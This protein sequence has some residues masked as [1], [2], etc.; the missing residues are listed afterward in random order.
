MQ[1][2][3]RFLSHVMW[4]VLGTAIVLGV[5]GA[6]ISFIG[7]EKTKPTLTVNSFAECATKYGAQESRPRR[8]VTPGGQT[9]TEVVTDEESPIIGSAADLV[10]NVLPAPFSLVTDPLVITGEAR[11][12]YFE[13]SF[14]VTL[15]DG[16]GNLIAEGVATATG[17]W[18]TEDFVPFTATLSWKMLPTTRSGIITLKKDNP[19]GLPEHDRDASY[20]V[21]FS[22]SVDPE[23]TFD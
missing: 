5:V 14:P 15:T 6:A 19:S 22:V 23:T 12:M 11:L 21:R 4:T 18:M 13:A 7:R 1:F 16:N 20:P 2:E 10:R 9:F 3:H 17:D 8:C